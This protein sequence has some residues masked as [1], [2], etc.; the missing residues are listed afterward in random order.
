MAELSVVFLIG[1][2]GGAHCIGMCGGFVIALTHANGGGRNGQLHQAMYFAGKTMT[3]MI[4]GALVGLF[5]AA[6]GLAF[7]GFQ[8]ILSLL[9]GFV[10]VIL[11]LGLVGI[12]RRFDGLTSLAPVRSL[13][14]LIGTLVRRQ[15]PV[16]TMGLGMLN[17]ALP[18]G[19]VY[20]VLVSAAGTGSVLG[21]TLTMG[22]FGLGTI[23]A[24][25]LVGVGGLLV[26]PSWRSR[27]SQV[28][29]ILVILLGL[30]TMVRGTP[31]MGAIMGWIH[32]SDGATE[33]CHDAEAMRH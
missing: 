12:L 33:H 22:A 15:T 6:L 7:S 30:A 18:C 8:Q 27:L 31:A 16:A 28:G 20:A 32:G 21:G 9:V 2:F 29:G 19:L 5:G 25:Y 10:L 13:S 14:K 24:L 26:R 17:G 4:F 11:G 23:P 1:L 3:Y